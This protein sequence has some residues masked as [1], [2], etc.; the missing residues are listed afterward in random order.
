MTNLQLV[1]NANFQIVHEVYDLL[2]DPDNQSMRTITN[3][4]QT[5]WLITKPNFTQ[6]LRKMRFSTFR[7]VYKPGFVNRSY[8]ATLTIKPLVVD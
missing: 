6:P 5:E 2:S 4:N 7:P 8:S 1:E 3:N